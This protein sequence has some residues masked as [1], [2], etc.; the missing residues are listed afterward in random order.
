MTVM[1]VNALFAEVTH[2]LLDSGY[3]ALPSRFNIGSI[4]FQL[5]HVFSGPPG[6]LSLALLQEGPNTREQAGH[7]YW[8]VQ[9]VVRALDVEGSRISVTLI[10][11]GGQSEDKLIGELHEISRVLLVDDSLPVARLLAPLMKISAGV[12]AHAFANGLA[13]LESFVSQKADSATLR[14][15]I[16]DATHG[17]DAV[18]Q[19]LRRWIDLAIEGN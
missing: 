4:E 19:G 11:V 9:R 6:T 14:V 7:L 16:D 3:A 15:L 2:R 10:L 5:E 1:N 18:K 17:P 8:L 13:V 12:S